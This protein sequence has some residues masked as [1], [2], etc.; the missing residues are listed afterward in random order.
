MVRAT[1][2]EQAVRV[3]NEALE[4]DPEA[5]N[6]LFAHREQC[7]II[8]ADHKTIQVSAD[9]GTCLPAYSVGLLGIINGIFG[10]DGD[11]WGAIVAEYTLKC[12]CDEIPDDAEFGYRCDVCDQKI[13]LGE[14][15]RFSDNGRDVKHV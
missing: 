6:A 15:Q 7:S 8:F 1:T 12:G 9:G 10:V 11:G 4:A 2:V 3:L 13:V 14:I 5:V